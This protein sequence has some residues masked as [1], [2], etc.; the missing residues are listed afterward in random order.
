MNL[1]MPQRLTSRQSI[2]LSH[3]LEIAFQQ[4]VDYLNNQR[5]SHEQFTLTLI[6]EKSQFTRFNQA[7]VRQT[8][9]VEDAVLRLMWIANQRSSY[10]EFP[11]TGDWLTDRQILAEA[12]KFLR[13]ELP[14]LPENPYLVLPQGDRHS[15][16]VH[17][18]SLLPAQ[19]L[20]TE[21]LSAVADVD[22]AGIYAGGLMVRAYADSQGQFHWFA[23][24]TF[25]LDYSF[26]AGT[27][28]AVKG[29][30]AGRDWDQ[31]AYWDTIQNS[32]RQLQR[33]SCDPRRLDRGQ[34][35]TYLAPAAIAEMVYM[36]SWGGV[37]EADI[38]Q[39]NSC[40]GIMRSGEKQLSPKFS[41]SENFSHGSV[42]RFNEF[43][44]I[45]PAV[46]PIIQ[47]GVLKNTLI[48]A[49]TAKEYQLVANGAA[50]GENLRSP[51]IAPGDLAEDQILSALDTG[52]YVSNLHYLNWSDRPTGRMTGMTRY[53]CFW[54]EDGEL[55]API[56]NLRFDDSFY[57]FWGENLLALTAHQVYIPDVGTYGHRALGGIWAPGMLIEDLTYTL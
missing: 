23:T 53:A 48:S 55:V 32:R 34:Y 51:D 6:A 9:Q 7:K 42:P 36:M 4:V 17:V 41:L 11:L 52:L 30:F 8:G 12:L 44:E 37:S 3:S 19:T 10:R 13:W 50:E 29:T 39:G 26:F 22:F 21:V 47:H 1:V 5:R 40:F 20:M 38:Q 2:N 46:L 33:L 16:E 43:G 54:V 35:R 15:H 27:G 45:A 49:K 24:E 57:T 14:Q 28:M 31:A 56:E 25:S 18:G